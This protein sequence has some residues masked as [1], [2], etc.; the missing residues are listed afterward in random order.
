MY[1]FL[2]SAEFQELQAI[3]LQAMATKKMRPGWLGRATG[4]FRFVCYRHVIIVLFFL[5]NHI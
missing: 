4:F 2:P 1:V 3:E 5:K